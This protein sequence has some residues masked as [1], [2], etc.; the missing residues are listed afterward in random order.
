MSMA[1]LGYPVTRQA[2]MDND[3][4]DAKPES[5]LNANQ[6]ESL[7]HLFAALRTNAAGSSDGDGMLSRDSKK[8]RSLPPTPG[9]WRSSQGLFEIESRFAGEIL[10]IKQEC[11]CCGRKVF[12][13]LMQNGQWY[14]AEV[15]ERT[16]EGNESV[17]GYVRLKME[18]GRLRTHCKK[19]IEDDWL[20]ECMSEKVEPGEIIVE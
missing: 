20:P 16:P 13:R 5:N 3:I 12:G 14:E 8:A 17:V 10:E 18:G 19:K 1:T 15:M 6:E 11:K 4:D 2:D 9:L 7:C